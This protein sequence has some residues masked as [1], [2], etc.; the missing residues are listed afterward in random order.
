MPEP[1]RDL[2]P[3]LLSAK[4]AAL[5]ERWLWP[6]RRGFRWNDLN[7][8]H[9]AELQVRQMGHRHRYTDH[10]GYWVVRFLPGEQ[11]MK[12]GLGLFDFQ[13]AGW[14]CRGSALMTLRREIIHQKR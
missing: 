14:K 7:H 2:K 9:R 3:P 10:L 11:W 12:G 8:I 13:C 5:L 4:N 6:E 1:L